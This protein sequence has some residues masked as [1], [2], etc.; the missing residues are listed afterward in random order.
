MS[1]GATRTFVRGP[2]ENAKRAV[3]RDGALYKKPA[4]DID[5]A[6]TFGTMCLLVHG[7]SVG[8]LGNFIAEGTAL[9]NEL[10]SVAWM[11]S[12]CSRW[13]SARLA[14]S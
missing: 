1:F 14:S 5:W 13:C 4:A 12:A 3:G 2:G 6:E 11:E 9:S 7:G 10:S 8:F